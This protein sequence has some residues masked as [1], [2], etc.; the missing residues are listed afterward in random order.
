MKKRLFTVLLMLVLCVGVLSITALADGDPAVV[1]QGTCGAAGNEDNVTWV[2]TDDGILT[3]SGT[4]EMFDFPSNKAQPYASY[5][6]QILKVVFG[7]GITNAGSFTASGCTNLTEVCFSSTITKIGTKAF[8]ND[9]SLSKIN[10]TNIKT[11]KEAAFQNCASL[12]SIKTENVQMIE[13][14]AFSNCS[15]LESAEIIGSEV[16][17]GQ[18]AFANSRVLE[19]VDFSSV[20]S[21]GQDAFRG[22]ALSGK[23][24]L[25]SVENIGVSAF[26]NLTNLTGVVFGKNISLVGGTAFYNCGLTELTLPKG[27]VVYEDGVFQECTNLKTVTI[28]SGVTAIG[29]DMFRDDTGLTTVEIPVSLA[30]I[31]DNAFNGCTALATVNYGG[32]EEEWNQINFGTGNDQL[33]AATI[34]FYSFADEKPTVKAETDKKTGKIKLT[35]TAVDGAKSYKIF[36]SEQQNGTYKEAATVT[37]TTYT[38]SGTPGKTYYFKVQAV[39]DKG[40][41]SGESN[42][43]SKVQLPAQVTSLKAASKKKQVTLKWKKVTGAK[44]YVIYMSK[45]GKSG[46]KKVG[47]TTKNTYVYKKGTVG[48]KLYFRVQAVTAN[49]KKGEFS[50]VVSVKVKK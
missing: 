23:I 22:T 39:N 40:E 10:L 14:Y 28:P 30:S 27:N 33:T 4:G 13:K 47:T 5:K 15:N 2:L 20:K 35:I 43:V 45:N 7:E 19:T 46:W 44:K 16:S 41:L 9:S 48:K 8:V 42:I 37:G 50:K 36:V 1:A 11:I 6:S 49:G 32:T 17:I 24:D 29:I 38:Y 26:V 3:I 31:P 18:L 12:T 25:S 34:N 21:I